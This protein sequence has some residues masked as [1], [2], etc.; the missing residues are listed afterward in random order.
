V[1]CEQSTLSRLA[2][3][4]WRKEGKDEKD[5]KAQIDFSLSSFLWPLIFVLRSH[6]SRNYFLIVKRNP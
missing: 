1:A 3:D 6:P 4:G 5:E 2:K